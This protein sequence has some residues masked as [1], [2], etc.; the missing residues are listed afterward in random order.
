MLVSNEPCLGCAWHPSSTM[1]A[2]TSQ[3]GQVNVFDALTQEKL[4]QLVSSEV[5]SKKDDKYN[6]KG[7]KLTDTFF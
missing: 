4:C 7:L 1:F 6:M 3:D 2:V 5:Q